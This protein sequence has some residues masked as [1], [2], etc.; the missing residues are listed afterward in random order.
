M[1]AE[2]WVPHP[3]DR[4]R[5]NESARRGNFH[6]TRADGRRRWVVERIQYTPGWAQPDIHMTDGEVWNVC[7]LE[8]VGGAQ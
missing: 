2:K 6:G 3:G 5:L 1:I 8:P 4:V 7:W